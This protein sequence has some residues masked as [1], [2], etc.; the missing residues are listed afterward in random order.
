MSREAIRRSSSQAFDYEP[1]KLAERYLFEYHVWHPQIDGPPEQYLD[2]KQADWTIRWWRGQRDL[3]FHQPVGYKY[4]EV[5]PVNVA[6]AGQVGTAAL[7]AA[8]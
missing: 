1:D 3:S 2:Q 5:G 7:A 4:G 6:V 8:E